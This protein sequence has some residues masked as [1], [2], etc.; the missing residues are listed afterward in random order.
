MRTTLQLAITLSVLLSS[1][2]RAESIRCPEDAYRHVWQAPDGSRVEA[3]LRAGSGSPIRHGPY[4]RFHPDGAVALE[5]LFDEG[6]RVGLWFWYAADGRSTTSRWYPA[7][8]PPR[9]E[10]ESPVDAASRLARLEQVRRQGRR[11]RLSAL[12]AWAGGAQLL[13]ATPVIAVLGVFQGPD[14][15]ERGMPLPW[16]LGVGGLGLFVSLAAWERSADEI[17]LLPGHPA[18]VNYG[19]AAFGAGL[20]SVAMVLHST[21]VISFA[22][23]GVPFDQLAGLGV[24]MLSLGLYLGGIGVVAADA[25]ALRDVARSIEPP[26]ERRAPELAGLWLAPTEGGIAGGLSLSVP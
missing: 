13:A 17:R 2:A 16:A 22:E 14:G 8:E 21:V 5:G 15:W 4:R 18:R 3:C 11:F 20:A 9:V 1:A 23:P 10:P 26:R 24:S 7:P 6:R 25:R 19:T 12:P